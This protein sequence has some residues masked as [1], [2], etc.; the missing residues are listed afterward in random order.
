MCHLEQFVH[1]CTAALWVCEEML[2]TRKRTSRLR[3]Y[4]VQWHIT[5]SLLPVKEHIKQHCDE[6]KG[7][8]YSERNR[9]RRTLMNFLIIF[10]FLSSNIIFKQVYELEQHMN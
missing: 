8:S 1:V 4:E 6:V 10:L 9:I 2:T 3:N 7:N 5:R